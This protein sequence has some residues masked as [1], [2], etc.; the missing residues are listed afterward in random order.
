MVQR[1]DGSASLR[2]ILGAMATGL[3]VDFA[4]IAPGAMSMVRGML[5]RGFLTTGQ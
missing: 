4:A 5:E 2:Q 1:F 3:N